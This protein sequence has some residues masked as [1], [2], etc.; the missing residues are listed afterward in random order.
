MTVVAPEYGVAL[1]P[2]SL[3]QSGQPGAT[4]TYTLIL[5]NAGN[6]PDSFAITASSSAWTTHFPAQVGPLP[7]DASQPVQITVDIPL[8]A[9][10]GDYDLVDIYFTSQSNPLVVGKATL[11]SVA[12]G[13]FALQ[14]SPDAQA[15]SGTPGEWITYTLA[16]T[17]TG[18]APETFDVAVS[19]GWAY[20]APPVIGALDAG[21]S[22]SFNIQVQ[23]PP[24]APVGD[25]SLAQVQV[26]SQSDPSQN[27]LAL[28]STTAL[29]SPDADLALG[30]AAPAGVQLGD[31]IT[32][33]LIVTNSGPVTASNS[34]LTA[35]LPLG[36]NFVSASPGCGAAAGLV[37]CA[38]GDVPPSASQ[39]LTIVVQA[40]QA[41][42]Q[43]STVTLASDTRDPDL[44]N[45]SASVSTIVEAPPPTLFLFLPLIPKQ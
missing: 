6:F 37:V 1:D 4:L 40:A 30:L 21:D 38:L 27:A 26:T 20:I 13:V 23:V 11:V 10:A 39:T 25:V 9:Q 32:Y 8:D 2:A 35:T 15:G 7:P 19:S 42:E 44:E 31:F 22:T 16:L 28:L 45:N 33:T 36:V 14:L 3:L 29:Q 18:N 41:G 34:L 17:N 43:T 24:G 12:Q 5:T